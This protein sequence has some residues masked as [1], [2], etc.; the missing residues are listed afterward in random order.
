[1]IN[2]IEVKKAINGDIY[3][4]QNLIESLKVYMY[5]IAIRYLKNEDDAGDAIGNTIILAYE[6]IKNLRRTKY[7]KTWLTRILI[8]ECNKIL[9]I[10]KKV[11]LLEDYEYTEDTYKEE[12][13]KDIDIKDYI[14]SLPDIQKSVILMYFYEEM[15]IEEIANTLQIATGTVKSRLFNAKKSFRNIMKMKGGILE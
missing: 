5:S 4:F 7:F 2:D 12:I 11:I 14:N 15:R 1:M 8:N 6:N 3:A 9:K 13:E 10:R